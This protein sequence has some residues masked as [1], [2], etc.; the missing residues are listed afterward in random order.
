MPKIFTKF[1]GRDVG[2]VIVDIMLVEAVYTVLTYTSDVS[3][4]SV[5]RLI[6]GREYSVGG[7]CL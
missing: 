2:Y 6:S 1:S 5:I 4:Y 3:S 7:K